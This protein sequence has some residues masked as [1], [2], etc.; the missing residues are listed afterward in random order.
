METNRF[1]AKVIQ[2][3]VLTLFLIPGNLV[4]G[5]ESPV[6]SISISLKNVKLEN[7]LRILSEKSG[8]EFIS[9]PSVK[10]KDISLE[11]KSIPPLEALSILTE[12]YDLGYEQLSESGIYIVTERSEIEIQT[13]LNTY[14]CEFATA[15]DLAS[16]VETIATPE[17]GKVFADNRTNTIIFLDTPGKMI[18]I[19]RLLKR[20]DKPTQQVYIKSLIAEITINKDTE[21]GVQWFSKLQ[22]YQGGDISIGTDFSA[23]SG[24]PEQ[25][26]FPNLSSGLGIGILDYDIDVA[27]G[28]LA[29]ISDL[30]V[31]STP[32]MITQDNQVAFIEVGDQIPYPQLNEYGVTSYE[33]K[34]A[35]IRLRIRPHINN[36]STITIFLEPQANFQQGYTPD[37]IPIIAKRSV[38]TRVVVKNNETVVIGGL[39]KESDVETVTKVPLLG[40]IPVLGSLFKLTKKINRKLS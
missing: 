18:E 2:I 11:L 40:S 5:Q 8:L 25:L 7:V 17:A 33:F 27:I 26:S 19:E 6:D 15:A 12:L 35:T 29:R 39:M 28:L 23:M 37:N 38:E 36:D 10:D 13:Q 16:V 3:L 22:N 4:H 32:Y 30:N 34:D 24:V 9:D 1:T 31:L 20:L 21:S 14:L